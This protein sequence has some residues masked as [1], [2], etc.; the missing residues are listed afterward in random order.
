MLIGII[1]V[2]IIGIG[3]ML[4]SIHE[5]IPEKLK[6]SKIVVPFYKV[7]S[8]I[9]KK[10]LEKEDNFYYRKVFDKNSLIYAAK[11]NREITKNYFIEKLGLC[12]LVMFVGLVF[13]LII[14]IKI[15]NESIIDSENSIERNEYNEGSKIV[16]LRAEIEGEIYE[17]IEVDISEMKYTCEEFE[18]SLESV[19]TTI[20]KEFLAKNESLDFVNSDVNLIDSVEDYPYTIEWKISDKSIIS[21]QG[22]I[23][24]NIPEEGSLVN[25]IAYISYEDYISEYNFSAYVFPKE[26]SRHEYLLNKIYELLKISE[27]ETNHNSKML[28]PDEVDGIK[29]HWSE[30]KKNTILIFI[31]MTIVIALGVFFGKDADLDKKIQERNNQMMEDYSEIISKFALL[32]GAGMTVVGAWKKIAGDYVEKNKSEGFHHYAYEEMVYTM[33]EME[34]GVEE[35][36]CYQHFANRVKVQKYIKMVS[37]LEQNIKMGTSGLISDLRKEVDDSFKERKSMAEKKGE[38]SATK[39]LLPMFMMLLIVMVVIMVPAFMSM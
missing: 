13:A 29:I 20:D 5:V 21:S 24:N 1:V 22:E 25:F 19:R 31:G 11:E 9:Y 18:N 37:L 34:S 28:L 35:S 4:I 16:R 14:G 38:E 7:G 10:V 26:M 32:V 36:I 39:L 3:L 2:L 12:Y 15:N 23:Q 33:Y 8:W 6:E 30:E 27:K 17:D